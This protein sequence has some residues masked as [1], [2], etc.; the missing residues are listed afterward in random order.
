MTESIRTSEM[1]TRRPLPVVH[2]ERHPSIIGGDW[3]HL[4]CTCSIGIDHTYEDWAD[5][6]AY[7]TTGAT[8]PATTRPE[9]AH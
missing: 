9:T 3:V 4:V 7:G 2:L 6:F 5:R 8:E 1:R